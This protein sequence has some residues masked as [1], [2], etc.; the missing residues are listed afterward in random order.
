MGSQFREFSEAL[1][2]ACAADQSVQLFIQTGSGVARLIGLRVQV[3]DIFQAPDVL[4]TRRGK[5]H[6]CSR[7]WDVGWMSRC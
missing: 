5:R 7:A 3:Q 1:R 4:G 2:L 6:P